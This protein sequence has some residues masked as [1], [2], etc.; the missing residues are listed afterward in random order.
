MR[1]TVLLFIFIFLVACGDAQRIGPTGLPYEGDGQALEAD[2]SQDYAN[3]ED[4]YGEEELTEVEFI[5]TE[6]TAATGG[7]IPD[8]GVLRLHMRP[9]HT[10]NPLLNQDVTV[11][12]V[13][14]LV[15]EPLAVLCE[16]F[17]VHGHLADLEFSPD[18]TK[19]SAIVREGAVWSD[20][21]PVTA[22]DII[23]SV[24]FLR[25]APHGA[26]YR[27]RVENIGEVVRINSRTVEIYF[28]RP[29]VLAAHSLEFPIIPQHMGENPV[30]SGPFA[31]APDAT[32]HGLTLRRNPYARTR[33][34]ADEVSVVFLPDAA[35]DFH[36]FERGLIDA[37]HMPLTEWTRRGGVRTPVYETY[38]A[39]YFE[40]VGFNF[41]RGIFRNIQTRRGISYAFNADE[42]V[43]SVFLSYAERAAMPIHPQHWAYDSTITPGDYNIMRASALLNTV[44]VDAPLVILANEDNPQRVAIA[45]RLASD[46]TRAGLPAGAEIVPAD[47]YFARL[48]AHDFDLFVGGMELSAAIDVRV[49]F[50]SSDLFMYDPL[51]EAAQAALHSAATEAEFLQ[52]MRR[53]QIAFA[54]Q[55][56]VIGMAFKH[57]AL[58]TSTRIVPPTQP[59]PGFVFADIHEWRIME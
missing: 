5:A 45:R 58:L 43:A 3:D 39:M 41:N 10:L 18:G 55:I 21:R 42:A 52:A 38:H 28:A 15:F 50:Q 44:R 25:T 49:F 12:R 37:L 13:L 7:L 54:E 33:A 4:P 32:M 19:V 53:L 40:F 20:G 46:L 30:G 24:N 56:P 47:E 36:A 14:R 17:R 29:S 48:T 11:A 26:V 22:D 31:F 2:A 16:N 23:F 51:I 35:T 57:S 59:A 8:D 34:Q 6:F 27:S 9:P 1:L